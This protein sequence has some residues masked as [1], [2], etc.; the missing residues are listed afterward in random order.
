MRQSEFVS[1]A[2]ANQRLR[3]LVVCH[4]RVF[5]Y[6]ISIWLTPCSPAHAA[7]SVLC[8]MER[9]DTQKRA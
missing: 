5:H 1:I 9:S 4:V 6:S 2:Q 8:N 7:E 3:K